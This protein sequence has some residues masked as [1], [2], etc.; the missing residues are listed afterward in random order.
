MKT[1]SAPTAMP[2]PLILVYGRDQ[3]LLETRSWVLEQAGY[4]TV[5]AMT[6]AGAEGLAKMNAAEV[7][8]LCHSLSAEESRGALASLRRLRPE[9]QRLV[10]TVNATAVS[11]GAQEAVLSA[12]EGPRQLLDEVARL[13]QRREARQ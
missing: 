13:V 9:V 5:Q 1:G 10:L 8:V 6:L 7:A 4:R 3:R 2:N 12:Y 11:D